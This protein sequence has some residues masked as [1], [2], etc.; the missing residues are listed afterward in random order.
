MRETSLSQ[1]LLL[2][3]CLLAGLAA[4]GSGGA[5]DVKGSGSGG[6]SAQAGQPFDFGE[7]FTYTPLEIPHGAEQ[8]TLP[9][10]K[11]EVAGFGDVVSRLGLDAGG[12]DFLLNHGF[13]VTDFRLVPQCEDV[14]KAYEM[15]AA[16][17]I[18][19]LVTSGS[20]LHTYHVL[21]DDLLSTIEAQHLYDNV[22]QMTHGLFERC[23][24]IRAE[25][26]G[27]LAEAALRDAAFLAVGLELMKPARS[28]VPAEGTARRPGTLPNPKEFEPG[29]TQKYAFDLPDE[30]ADI[31]EAELELIRAHGGASP[32][33]LFVYSED[34]SQYVPRGHYTVSEKLKNYFR[35]MMWFGRMTMLL[36][37]TD[38]VVP[39]ESCTTC[40]A[41]ISEYDARIQTLGG[42]VLSDIMDAHHGLMQAWERT[43]RVTSFFVGFSDDL[44]PY[45]YIE[46]MNQVFGDERPLDAYSPADHDK[47]K[48][49]LAEL[50]SPRIY[51]GT[52][53]CVIPPPFTPEQADECLAATR[54]FRLMGQRFVPDSY[55]LSK[56][57]APYT[58]EFLGGDMPFTAYRIPGVGI[59]RVFPRG[60]DVMAVLGSDRAREILD[61]L[62]DTRYRDYDQAFR[63]VRAEI[64]SIEADAWNQ[65]LYWNWLWSLKALLAGEGPGYPA[66]M[67]SDAWKDRL[68]KIALASWAELRHDTILYVKQSYTMALT[69]MPMPRVALGYVEPVPELYSRLLSLT[70]MTRL[71]LASMDLLDDAQERRLLRL[72]DLLERVTS[73]SLAELRG[74]PL[75]EDDGRYIGRFGDAL[76]GVL[77]GVE[78][79]S[80]KTTVVADV[81]TDMNSGKVLEQGVGYVDLLIVAWKSGDQ[82]YLAAGPELSYY[83]FKH[84]M[85]DRLTDEAW[86]DML[87]T[88]PP[89]RPAWLPQR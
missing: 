5:G 11:D 8:Y 42:L 84:P 2:L 65:N 48:V 22:W 31:V 72:E 53:G 46:T 44:G 88:G 27:D 66:F 14:V 30:V 77:S 4:C 21:F 49:K 62:G 79:K 38:E 89:P 32:S 18:P 24:A 86:R 60:L 59:A 6:E 41:L 43:Y 12:T 57:V 83:E 78:E 58:G 33:P 69:A 67:R 51:G 81:H 37:G 87:R 74:D 73:I 54:G 39:G 56:L 28:Q 64:D 36:K 47:L 25:S 9:L 10:N 80:Q 71:G 52:G 61:D 1:S 29:D 45:E 63:D 75:D 17:E 68:L 85:A 34:Y 19:V 23:L 20:L 82:V 50:R 7:H 76:D 16:R 40:D 15:I 35:A 13:A 3:G 55:I 26:D 70:R